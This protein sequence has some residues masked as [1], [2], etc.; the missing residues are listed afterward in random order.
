MKPVYTYHEV[1]SEHSALYDDEIDLRELFCA[2]WRGKWIILLSTIVFSFG[3]VYYALNLP[4]IYRSDVLLAPTQSSSQGG[5]SRMAA[6]FGG[7]AAL[8]GVDLGGQN[9]DQTQLAVQVMKSRKFISEFIKKHQLLAPLVAGKGWNSSTNALI[10][11]NTIY[12][13]V[14]HRWLGSKGEPSNAAKPTEQQAYGIFSGI[15]TID[16]DKGSGLYTVSVSFYS[17][18]IAKE[19]VTLLIEDINNVMRERSITETSKNLAYL[20]KQLDK[21]SIADMQNTFYSLIEDQ[22]KSL[23]LAEVQDE[24]IFKIIDPA[25]VPESKFKPKRSFIVIL[26]TLLGGIL[27]I[28]VVLANFIFRTKNRDL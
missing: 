2:L 24:F 8:A 19:W 7:L 4:N 6:Q 1:S 17:P 26:G 25:V 22:T 9:S 3:A 20:N 18:Y 16:Q 28:L 5:L 12:D 10:Y 15:F 27:G 21:T 13:D 23:M 11:D 14:N